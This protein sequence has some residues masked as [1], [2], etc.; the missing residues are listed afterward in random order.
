MDWIQAQSLRFLIIL[1]LP[2]ENNNIIRVS[3]H[4][5]LLFTHQN[6]VAKQMMYLHIENRPGTIICIKNILIQNMTH[7]VASLT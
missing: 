5:H 6:F 1:N 2:V 4:D 3:K 7:D